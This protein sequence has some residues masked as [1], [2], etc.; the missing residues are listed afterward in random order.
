[1]KLVLTVVIGC[2]ILTF[3]YSQNELSKQLEK[4]MDAH[5]DIN[6]FSGTVLVTRNDSVLLKKCYGFADIEWSVENTIET[7]F[8]LASVSK[9]FTAVAILQLEE[10]GLLSLNDKLSK[11]HPEFPK[12]EFITIKMLLTHNSGIGD[13]VEELFMSNTSLESDSVVKYI[14]KK[15]LLFEPGTQTSY[16]NTGYYLLTTIIEKTTKQTFVNYLKKHVLEKAKMFDSGISSN[17]TIIPR[18][19]KSYYHKNG[20]LIKN[21]YTNWKYNIGLDGVYSTIEDLYLWNK[22]L[23]DDTLVLS[24]ESKAKMFMSYNEHN[25]GYGVLVNPFYNHG[26]NLIGHDGGW[27][28]TQTSLNKFTGR[29]IFIAILSNNES[30][31]YLL[32]YGLSAIVFGKQVELPYKHKKIPIDPE[33]FNDYVGQ[34]EDVKIH[35]KDCKLYYSDYN[36]E[37]IPESKTKFFRADNDDRTIEFV[38]NKK[39]KTIQIIITKVGVREIKNKDR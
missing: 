25:F 27:F 15:P 5:A 4:Y 37:L 21:P 6:N 14:M 34:Y 39:G 13:D 31:S 10:K 23:F 24:K 26:Q 3:G 12:G 29:N 20:K 19:A 30:P 32:A 22:Y 7:K 8:S 16:S 2:L 18:M 33:T 1:M 36:I 35:Q 38:Q 9:Q 17:E 11:Y 28:G